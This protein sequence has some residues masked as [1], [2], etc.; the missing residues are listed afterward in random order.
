MK[1]QRH[2]LMHYLTLILMF[3]FFTFTHYFIYRV[4][5]EIIDYISKQKIVEEIE[6]EPEVAPILVE[7]NELDYTHYSTVQLNIENILQNPELPTGCEVTSLAIV[8][9]YLGYDIDKV[10]LSDLFLPKGEIGKTHPDKAFIGNPRDKSAYGAN[11]PVLVNTAN[12]Y[13]KHVQGKHYAYNMSSNEFT[14]LLKYVNDGYPVMF[15]GTMY[16]KDGYPSTKWIID[17]ETVQWYARFHCMVLIGYTEDTYIIA[18]PLQGIVEYD[19]DLVEKRY[20]EL[21]KQAIV[22][23]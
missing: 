7:R 6:H 17:N 12:D 19:K 23:Y 2:K 21:G 1:R 3:F 18:D 9:N 11:A 15:W 5:L 10:L 22:I 14:D 20:N 13:L 16:M 8:L 4:K